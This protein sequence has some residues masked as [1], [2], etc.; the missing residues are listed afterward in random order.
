[1]KAPASLALLLLACAGDE[2]A[3]ITQIV[4]P[5]VLAIV[6]EP[7]ALAV[8]GAIT[9][10]TISVDP[11]GPRAP[12]AVRIRACSP[13]R[14]IGEPAIDCAGSDALPLSGDAGTFTVSTQQLIDAFPP[15]QGTAN[16]ETLRVALETGVD[17]RIPTIAEVEIDGETLIAR[18][19]LHVVLDASELAN[20][21][22]AEV[23]FDG[24]S[25]TTLDAGRTYTLTLAYDPDSFDHVPRDPD[26]PR[27]PELEEF[28]CYFYSP[29]GVLEA[30]ERDVEEPDVSNETEPNEYTA[31]PA[32]D[33]WMFLVA[34][35]STGGMTADAVPLRVE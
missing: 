13:W 23:R 29:S 27:E 28:D 10:S 31:G 1:M 6:S 34:T 18:R 30:H 11:T 8:D 14:F 2:G 35:D 21:R 17:I 20:P 25:T 22:L 26:D 5:R 7:S 16:L 24:E 32:G 4:S 33:T 19:D 15:P 9:L 3:P 12:D